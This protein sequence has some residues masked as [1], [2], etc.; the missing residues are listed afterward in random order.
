[1]IAPLF[2][3]QSLDNLGKLKTN[4]CFLTDSLALFYF[5]IDLSSSEQFETVLY[6]VMYKQINLR[7]VFS[8]IETADVLFVSSEVGNKFKDGVSW[9]NFISSSVG[10]YNGVFK[11][12]GYS[13]A[14][15]GEFL[16]KIVRI[17]GLIKF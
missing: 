17:S 1:M 6:K 11:I 13:N 15:F 3:P 14:Y 8:G 12:Y 5:D 9:G 7:D 10:Y 2:C 16:D 4:L